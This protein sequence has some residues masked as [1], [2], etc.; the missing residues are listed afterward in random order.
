MNGSALAEIKSSRLKRYG[1]RGASHLTPECV[2]LVNK[3]TL[4]RTPYRGIAGHICYRLKRHSEKNGVVSKP[5]RRE[6]RLDPGMT[7]S[8]Y[9]YI[10]ALRHI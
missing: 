2:Y 8:Y 7:R 4:T 5:S 9:R 6:S 10:S 1:I 3:M